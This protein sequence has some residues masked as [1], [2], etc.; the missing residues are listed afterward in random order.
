M[1]EDKINVVVAMDFSDEIMETIRNV[2]PRLNVIKHFPDVPASIW[3]TTEV[4]YT[5]RTFP[6][7]E[8]APMLRWIQLHSAGMERALQYRIVQAED[9]TVTSTSGIHATQIA[10]YCL[11]MML[12]FNYK[13]PKMLNFQ[14][15][16]TWADNRYEIFVPTDLQ[17]QTV[18]IAGYGSI[19][20][21][22]ARIADH[23]GMT[24]LAS[25]RNAKNPAAAPTD[26]IPEGHGDAEGVIPER[27]YP[28]EAIGTMASDCDYLVITTPLTENT[29]HM[30]NERVLD[31]MKDTAVLINIARGAVVD[32]KALIT[33]LSQEKIGG[34][35][36]D[37]FEEEPLPSTSPLW[38]MDNVIISPHV[39]GMVD[40]YHEKAAE[41]FRVNLDRYL[42]KRPLYNQLNREVGY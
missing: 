39:S 19:G 15:E 41:V 29:R 18:G 1:G 24:V 32:E 38:Q 27:I 36:L 10:N 31:M 40:N 4:L 20:R 12:A 11:M 25:K 34:A 17:H 6:E 26:Y 28:G 3:A 21:E 37:V 35:A 13:L 7:P 42:E 5:T 22:L 2:S 33:A 16:S 30:V 23:L 9:V 14:R 8:D